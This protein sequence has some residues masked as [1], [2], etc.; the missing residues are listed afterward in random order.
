MDRPHCGPQSRNRPASARPVSGRTSR[1]DDTSAGTYF[2]A[3]IRGFLIGYLFIPGLLFF[4]LT[5]FYWNRMLT[6]K[7][8]GEILHAVFFFAPMQFLFLILG[9]YLAIGTAISASEIVRRSAGTM[10]WYEFFWTITQR[11]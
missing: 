8:V 4:I 5:P 11:R 6:D 1:R 7:V 3:S 10:S 2:W 9:A